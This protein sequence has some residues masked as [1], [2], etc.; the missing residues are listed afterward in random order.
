[1]KSPMVTNAGY[2]P[3]KTGYSDLKVM[4]SAAGYYIGTTYTDPKDG[5]TEP[6]SRDSDYFRTHEEAEKYL[7]ML[8]SEGDD[9]AA[10]ELRAT[11]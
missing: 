6:G 10:M 11:P 9:F 1:M 5:F 2:L 7:K 4:Q 3:E 8:E